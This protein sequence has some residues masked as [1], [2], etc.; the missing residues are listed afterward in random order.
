M[1]FIILISCVLALAVSELG[2]NVPLLETLHWKLYDRLMRIK[3]KFVKPPRE[4]SDILL[5]VIDNDTLKIINERW[6]YSRSYF[7]NAIENLSHAG[8]QLI[9]FDFAFFG[10]SES[11]SDEELAGALKNKRVILASTIDENGALDFSSISGLNS[12][13]SSGIVTKLQDPDG[14]I[15]RN[16]TY[17]VSSKKAAQGFLSWE[18][19][20][21][22][23]VKNLDFLTMEM[24]KSSISV[25]SYG[26][27]KLVIP[28]DPY[29]KSFLINF[30]AHTPDFERLSFNRAL[31]GNFDPALVKDKI[32][33]V[34]VLSSLLGDV[35][36]TSIGW[37]PGITLNANAFLTLYAQNFINKIPVF[38]EKILLFLGVIIAAFF[39]SSLSA[40]KASFLIAFEILLFFTFSYFLLTRG[41]TWNYIYFPVL[42]IACPYLAAK[43]YRICD[44]KQK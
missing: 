2:K 15:R 11:E 14:I 41:Y 8:P 31:S 28:V 35:H 27:K 5:V 12:F 33:M 4:I 36:N 34:G 40:K 26:G 20:I 9:G 37:L 30:S 39:A 3:Y 24:E 18:M 19:Q 44:R 29:S 1:V 38:A 23:A 43:I 13:E 6:P 21:L 10:K 7:A 16:L 22:R 42:V 32:V 17:L 25:N